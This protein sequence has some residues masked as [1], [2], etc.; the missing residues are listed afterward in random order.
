MPTIASVGFSQERES[1]RAAYAAARAAKRQL[2]GQNA[3]LV[4]FFTC[5]NYEF[6]ALLSALIEVFPQTPVVGS[7]GAGI[8]SN[9]GANTFGIAVAAFASDT[10]TPI[11]GCIQDIGTGNPR[12][13][14]QAFAR[15]LLKK[16]A[17]SRR[18]MLT[19]FLDGQ[20]QNTSLF[21]KGLQETLGTSFPIVGGSSA[22]D[23]K[24]HK[25]FQFFNDKILTDACVGILWAGK[26]IFSFGI[27]HG[28]NP[29]GKPR[30]VTKAKDNIIEEID[31]L[32]AV[33]L[34]EE[35]FGKDVEDLKRLHLARMA[36]LYPLGVYTP[37][38]EEYLL[39]N[40]I[41]LTENQG[42]I[43]QGDV[44]TGAEIRLMIGTK[45]MCLI[46]SRKAALEAKRPFEKRKI[47]FSLIFDS[48]ARNKLL[49]R[50]ASLEISYIKNI[51]GDPPLIGFYS[52][53]EQ[54]PLR[55][56]E[57]RGEAYFQNETVAITAIGDC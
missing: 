55:S 46:A 57:Y 42:L 44:L 14:A 31:G 41:G 2:Y 1:F 34:Y 53:G 43:C 26:G 51:L 5:V 4:I 49:G 37:G 6:K 33:K 16:S 35:Y 9:S 48:A 23:L 30:V 10:I 36:I 54:A 50:S 13:T 28:W 3:V 39:R 24:F 56:M 25:T 29:L 27:R 38:E 18:E 40:V 15:D 19:I 47:A 21:L 12:L 17:N 11:I 20:L 32:P 8:I 22:D 45:D 7:S 52:F